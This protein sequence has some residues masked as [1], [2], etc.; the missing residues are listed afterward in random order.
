MKNN[1]WAIYHAVSRA[2]SKTFLMYKF[3]CNSVT[4]PRRCTPARCVTATAILSVLLPP[5]HRTRPPPSPRCSHFFPRRRGRRQRRPVRRIACAELRSGSHPIPSGG[6]TDNPL[7]GCPRW[8]RSPLSQCPRC[9]GGGGGRGVRGSAV[10]ALT[11]GWW[12]RRCRRAADVSGTWF[13]EATCP[14][15]ACS[16]PGRWGGG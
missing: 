8:R 12:G 16:A 11:V 6:A 9:P 13:A 15:A 5:S 10:A 4:G 14:A 2:C 3:T 7:R 1:T